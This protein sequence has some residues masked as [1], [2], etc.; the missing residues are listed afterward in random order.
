MQGD[1]VHVGGNVRFVFTSAEN[2]RYDRIVRVQQL[3]DETTRPDT[4]KY[5]EIL[6]DSSANLLSFAGYTAKSIFDE[7]N[8]Q[9]S[10]G[11]TNYF[12]K[13]ER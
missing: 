1:E 11:L 10:I 3:I 13:R 6:Y 12:S 4:R 8:D 7:I 5:L 9:K 2:K